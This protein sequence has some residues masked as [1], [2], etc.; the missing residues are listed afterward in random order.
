MMRFFKFSVGIILTIL[1][2]AQQ[3]IGYEINSPLC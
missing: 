3:R 1:L 2:L